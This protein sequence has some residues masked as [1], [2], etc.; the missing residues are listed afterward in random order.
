MSCNLTVYSVPYKTLLAIPGS[1]DKRLMEKVRAGWTWSYNQ[2]DAMIDRN[3]EFRD[4]S[5]RTKLKFLDVLGQI[6][7]GKPLKGAE[8]FVY[9]YAVESICWALGK[10][11]DND[12][13]PALDSEE[14]DEFLQENKVPVSIE[15]LGQGE[16]PFPIPEPDDFPGIGH[17]KPNE[18][19]KAQK[20]LKKID[21]TKAPDYIQAM[22]EN[23]SDWLNAAKKGEDCLVGFVY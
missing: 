18:I 7:D 22:V 6:L 4:E 10:Q 5:D 8:G 13:L 9:G 15:Q 16:P 23:I 2:I 19:A 21:L 17:W 11:L 1:K 14:I 3:N 20:A 12:H